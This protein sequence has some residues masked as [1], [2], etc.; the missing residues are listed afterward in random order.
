MVSSQWPF[1]ERSPQIWFLKAHADL[2]RYWTR[3][4][5][6]QSGRWGS[7]EGR[8]TV[9]LGTNVGIPSPVRAGN[10]GSGICSLNFEYEELCFRKRRV[11]CVSRDA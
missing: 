11:G 3:N 8:S 9:T 2:S 5:E 1:L 6:F 10:F 7:I 4:P